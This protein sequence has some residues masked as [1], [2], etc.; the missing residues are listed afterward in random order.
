M[1]AAQD[2]ALPIVSTFL[3]L[4]SAEALAVVQADPPVHRRQWEV[5][6]CNLV[7]LSFGNVTQEPLSR[8]W[9]DGSALPKARTS[10]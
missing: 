2:E 7:P 1:Q 5:C 4:E 9:T 8:Y 10:V 6:P 3:Y